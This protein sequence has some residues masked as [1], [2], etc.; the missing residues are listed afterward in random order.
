MHPLLSN[1][2]RRFLPTQGYVDRHERMR[3]SAGALFGLVLTGSVTFLILGD[4]IGAAWLIA[5]MGAS[6]VLLFGVPSSPLAQP[7]SIIGGN[8]VAALIGVTCV[9]LIDAPVIAAGVAAGLSIACMFW[10]R[11]IHPPSGAVA[12][13]AVLGGPAV[14]AMGY[15][16]VLTPVMINSFLMVVTALLYNNA[17]RRTYPHHPQALA[18]QPK[19]HDTKDLPP[20][21]RTGITSKDLDE[22]LKHY[23]EVLDISRGD[24]EAILLQTEMQAYRRK[25]GATRCADIMSKD[26]VTAEF[27]TPLADA[28]KL[29]KRHDLTALP[30]VDRGRHVVGIVTKADYLAHAESETHAGI[31]KLLAELLKPSSMSHSEKHEVVGQI[32]TKNV[33]TAQASQSIVDLVPLMSDRE[34]HQVPVV[35]ENR[36]LVGILSQ[37]DLI[38]ALYENTMA[39]R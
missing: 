26:V 24:L 34:L 14:H 29:L 8:L 32:M 10:L 15:E 39:D 2:F 33:I 30:V 5:P 11:C 38:A 20:T 31:G 6:S 1:W 18:E 4:T 12:L 25:I 21:E 9:K 17:T 7:W 3:A 23:D 27:G 36:K 35:D 19:K 22:V 13:T 37:T 28:W 16:F